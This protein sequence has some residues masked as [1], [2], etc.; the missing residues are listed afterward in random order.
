MDMDAQ[1]CIHI[2][3]YSDL[4]IDMGG[5]FSEQLLPYCNNNAFKWHHS[6]VFLQNVIIQITITGKEGLQWQLMVTWS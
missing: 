2:W 1:I 4:K 6:H 3:M 5:Y